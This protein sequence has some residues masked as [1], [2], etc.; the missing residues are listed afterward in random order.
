M[1]KYDVITFGEAMAMFMADAAAPLHQVEHFTRSLAGAETN[2]AI[3]LSRLNYQVSWASQVGED[4]FGQF[5]KEALHKEGVDASHIYTDSRYPTG[6]Q[7][8]SKVLAGDPQVQY[9]R[10]NSAASHMGIEQFSEEHFLSAGHL[11]VT[12]IPPALSESMRG[13]TEKAV[14]VMKNANR[15]ISFDPNLRPQ[16]WDSKQTMIGEINRLAAEADWVLPGFAEGIILTGYQ[17]PQ[18]IA[19]YYLDK[20]VQAVIIK[21]G[22]EGAY[23]RTAGQEAVIPGFAVEKVVDTVGAGDGFAVGF[24]SGMLDGLPLVE[25]VTRANAIGALAV[26]SPGDSDGLPNREKLMDFVRKQRREEVC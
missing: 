4:A 2:V 23:Y 26:M 16:L 8:K 7:L 20:G 9:Y 18:D 3:G 24:I 22:E 12:G 13:Y 25:A 10:K 6:F 21:L 1:R 14:S 15:T 5:I 19:A 17:T 11:H